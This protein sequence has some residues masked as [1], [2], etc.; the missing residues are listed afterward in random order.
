MV[1]RRRAPGRHDPS[2]ATRRAA[3]AKSV[4]ENVFAPV[5]RNSGTL[6]NVTVSE[7][8]VSVKVTEPARPR[9]SDRPRARRCAAAR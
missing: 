5:S 7:R 8:D 2:I 1:K 6:V 9:R 3:T 4:I